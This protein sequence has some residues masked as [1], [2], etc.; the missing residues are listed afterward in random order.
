MT[1]FEDERP[2]PEVHASLQLR[3][4]RPGTSGSSDAGVMTHIA[5]PAARLFH[6]GRQHLVFWLTRVSS[7]CES[8]V[9]F[10]RGRRTRSELATDVEAMLATYRIQRVLPVDAAYSMR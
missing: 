9:D 3:D 2:G 1:I 7:V 8:V 6:S 10:V 4:I 5:V